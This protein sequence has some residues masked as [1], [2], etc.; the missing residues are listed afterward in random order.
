[1]ENNDLKLEVQDQVKIKD[2][3]VEYEQEKSSLVNKVTT[4]ERAI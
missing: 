1:M 2:Y 4:L 3:M